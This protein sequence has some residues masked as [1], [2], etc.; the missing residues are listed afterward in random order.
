MRVRRQFARFTAAG[1]VGYVVDVGL[2]YVLLALGAGYFSGRVISFLCA[3]WCTWII[4]R[5]VT[6]GAQR[7]PDAW[8]EWWTYLPA[9]LPGA[10]VNYAIYSAIVLALPVHALV[11]GLAVTVGAVLGLIVNF[12]MARRLVFRGE[13]RE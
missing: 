6:F 13:P 3:V 4:N 10:A 5:R 12:A 8:R 11:P 2:L 1:A 7:R 9:M